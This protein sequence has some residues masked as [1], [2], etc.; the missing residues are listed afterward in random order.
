MLYTSIRG[1]ITVENNDKHEILSA[2]TELLEEI[3][4]MN[5]LD[6]ENIVSILFTATND[7]TKVYPAV[8]ARNLGVKEAGL[9]C[10][11]ELYVEDSLQKC[12]RVL[13]NINSNK[14][15][16]EMK[17]IY[18]REAEKLRPDLVIANK[19]NSEISYN[20]IAIDGPNGAGKSTIAK[21]VA[22]ELEFIY[23][24]TGAMYRVIGFYCINNNIDL[25]DSNSIENALDKIKM[26]IEFENG[27]QH[28][29]INDDE[30]TDKIRTQ[31]VAE[32]AS[33]VAVNKKVREKLVYLQQEM[34]KNN[35]V[36][37]DGRDIGTK[38]LPNAC[39]KIYLYA[40]L[41]ERT[42]RRICELKEKG[43]A[44]DFN[45]TKEEI[46]KRDFR[47]MNREFS[48]L[49]KADDAIVIDTSNMSMI[50]VKNEII[51]IFRE[52]INKVV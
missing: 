28:I 48:P 7:L 22:K 40:T 20:S 31:Q 32:A 38:V 25:D 5:N 2:T 29:F 37:M 34:S 35:N 18:L 13:V 43:I 49:R 23:I 26:R 10:M 8:A 19:T 36:V 44:A 3:I 16:S 17:H 46:E 42:N 24:D 14:K 51:K 11:Q 12:I 30:V 41:E 33:K 39:L 45:K 6:I 9:M 50:Q 15:Q 1:A 52:R 47:D 21:E 4:K 27:V